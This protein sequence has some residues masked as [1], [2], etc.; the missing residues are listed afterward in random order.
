MSGMMRRVVL[1][2][3]TAETIVMIA[4]AVPR[5]QKLTP[6]DLAGKLSGTWV[7]NRDLSTGFRSPGRRGGAALLG[8]S[9]F[10]QRGRG[11]GGGGRDSGTNDPNDLTPEQRAA[12]AAMRQLQQVAERIVIKASAESVTFTD[13]RGERTFAIDDKASR[14][15]VDGSP[16]NV[17]SKWDKN[18]LRQEFS[19]PQAKLA[20]TW[21]VDDAGRLV[22]TAKLESMTLMTPDEK[23]LFDR[24]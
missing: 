6:A 12:Q 13:T 3:V 16:V 21:S 7:L 22:L 17:K 4:G 11:G 20:E 8:A 2:A 10:A 24:Q 5:A 15:D 9:V 23:A 19:N 18:A 14:I 1:W